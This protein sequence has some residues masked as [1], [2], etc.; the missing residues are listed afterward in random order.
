MIIILSPAKNLDLKTNNKTQIHETPLFLDKSHALINHLRLMSMEQITDFMKISPKLAQLN[1][2]RF[3]SWT[4]KHNTYNSLQAILAFKGDVYK[5]L[6]ADSL[7]ED[8]LKFANKHVRILSG[9]YGSLKAMSLVQP[10]RL[11]MGKKLEINNSKNLYEYWSKEITDLINNDLKN[12]NFNYLINLASNEYSKSVD[13]SKLNCE[14]CTP[15]FKDFKNGKYKVI[16]LYAKRARGLMTRFII[17]N[18]ITNIEDLKAFNS[19][20]YYYNTELSN[21]LQPVFTRDK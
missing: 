21:T 18:N 14:I 19:E 9:L 12:N 15:I 4:K 5:G 8:Q 17:E 13:F 11:E 7:S 16:S 1:H 20:G 3:Q 6:D 10:Y 2:K